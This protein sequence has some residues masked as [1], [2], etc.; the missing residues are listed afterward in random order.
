[1]PG[2]E[3]C[4]CGDIPPLE[5]TRRVCPKCGGTLPRSIHDDRKVSGIEEPRVDS[6]APQSDVE[7]R[8]ALRG[9][10]SVMGRSAEQS[11]SQPVGATS[12]SPV[13]EQTTRVSVA[14]SVRS[15][16]CGVVSLFLSGLAF[17]PNLWTAA[18]GAGLGFVALIVGFL[19][20]GEIRSGR[21]R[22]TGASSAFAG[23]ILGV[24]SM[25]LGPTVFSTI[26]DERREAAARTQTVSN[27]TQ[28]GLALDA[29][30]GKQE[31]F[32]PGGTF[33]V[34]NDGT[35]EPMH[36]WM[37]SLLPHLGQEELHNSIDLERPYDDPANRDA[38]QRVVA[39]FN[40]PGMQRQH[41]QRG[42]ALSGFAGLGGELL[43]DEL[44][45]RS[46]GVFER[47]S[48]VSRKE[49]TDGL[50]QTLVAGQ[51]ANDLPEWGSPG[52]WRTIGRGLNRDRTGFGNAAGTG[53]Y[54]LM[55]DG[56]VRFFSN[57]TSAEV[58]SGLS[59]RNGGEAVGP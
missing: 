51:V 53:A 45:Y 3:T 47:N 17:L 22:L 46:V 2:S 41:S 55:A 12:A 39:V 30:H 50:S 5:R 52:N 57:R 18:P 1:M 19:A 16:V 59:T 56:S 58:L 54:F 37:T 9:L 10:W 44:G 29:F 20:L 40:T 28:L 33:R 8:P 42:L 21:G 24:L 32:P 49:I 13:P 25:F 23:M 38:M 31:H 6:D 15:L 43:D 36:G 14:N 34:N 27:L 11:P 4:Q 48:R 7:E 26:G 35:T